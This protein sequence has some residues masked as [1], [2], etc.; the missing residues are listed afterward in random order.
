MDVC[1]EPGFGVCNGDANGSRESLGEGG[2]LSS[3]ASEEGRVWLSLE[4][5]DTEKI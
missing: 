2:R 5:Q 1:D 4:Y 3:I